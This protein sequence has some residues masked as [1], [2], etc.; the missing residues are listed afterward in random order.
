VGFPL[1]A[2]C[3]IMIRT[4]LVTSARVLLCL[5]AVLAASRA[6]SPPQNAN[7]GP[8]SHIQ[9]AS[10]GYGFP[11]G[12]SLVYE[13]EWRLLAAGTARLSME[14]SG[15]EQ[16]ISA[17]ADSRGVV[18]LLYP[19]HDRF[20]SAFEHS[21]LCSQSIIKHTEEGFRKRETI[22]N[23]NYS[24]RRS[25]LDETNLKNGQKKHGENEIPGC[26]TDV[27]SGIFYLAA[28]MLAPSATYTFPMNDG[29][30]TVDVTARVEAR[31]T[32]KT[33]A[34][35]FAAIRVSTEAASGP[36]KERGKIW[37]WY[38]DDGRHLPVQ[39]RARLFWGGL[40]F[41]LQRVEKK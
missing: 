27:V 25:V 19:V 24:R 39:M 18:S 29:G 40:I 31:E 21:S 34:G 8:L 1:K 22:I 32:V 14:A 11:D 20:Q 10:S 38:S 7:I 17:S 15:N 35:S 36:L 2:A 28:Q 23:F 41:R 16:H 13:A 9:P 37:I 26:V 3:M 6:Q 5:A 33:P 4:S 12:Q 30:N